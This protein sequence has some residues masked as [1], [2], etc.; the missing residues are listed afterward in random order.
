MPVP[1]GYGYY[2][3]LS[4]ANGTTLSAFVCRVDLS[5]SNF[6]FA[7]CRADGA[8][9]RPYDETADVVLPYWLRDFDRDAQKGSLRFLATATN[10]VIKI[11]YGNSG[12]SSASMYLQASGGVFLGGTGFDVPDWGDLATT[13]AGAT[14]EVAALPKSA[15]ISD[16]R[17]R[18]A[19]R[20]RL[21]PAI[22]ANAPGDSG[23]R[24]LSIVTDQYGRIVTDGSGNW[25]CYIG[26]QPAAGP[27][28]T[29]RATSSDE[30]ET[31][32]GW[33]LA[34]S[35]G[36]EAYDQSGAMAGTVIRVSPTSFYMFYTATGIAGG[37]GLATAASIMGPWTKQGIVIPA[38]TSLITSFACISV[39]IPHVRRMSDGTWTMVC[40]VRANTPGNQVWSI[41]G[42]QAS[43]IDGPWTGMNGGAVL[44]TGGATPWGSVGFADPILEEITPSLYSLFADG[45]TGSD[46]TNW[47]SF[48][49]QAGWFTNST[50]NNSSWAPDPGS[51]PLGMKIGR[52]GEHTEF[53]GV[54]PTTNDRV[55]FAARFETFDATNPYGTAFKIHPITRR[56][57][58]LV[59]RAVGDAAIAGKSLAA[60]N[61]VCESS[62]YMTA[63]RSENTDAY[64]LSLIDVASLPTPAPSSTFTGIFRV[65]IRRASFDHVSNPGGIQL[66]YYT[67]LDV[68]TFWDGS[69]WGT[70][71]AW[72]ASDTARE[73]IARIADDGS[74][75]ILTAAYADDDSV[76]ATATVSKATVKPFVNPRFML[77]GDMFT[78]AAADGM[79]Y[80]QVGVRP[81]PAGGVEPAYSLGAEVPIGVGPLPPVVSER[82][83]E[84]GTPRLLEDGSSRLL[85][86]SGMPTPGES[87]RLLE[88]GTTR[89]LEDG[90]ARLLEES[91]GVPLPIEAG[92]GLATYVQ[93]A[94]AIDYTPV[95]DIGGGDVIV[96]GG[97]V[98]VTKR[99]IFAGELGALRVEGGF[100]VDKIDGEAISFMDKIYW[101]DTAKV[102]TA[103]VK[104]VVMGRCIRAALADDFKV[105]VKLTFGR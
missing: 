38:N 21:T 47:G 6:G 34:L 11:C 79:F 76:I 8:D 102:A 103:V 93:K 94:D 4:D 31:W 53:Q 81:Y 84:D 32:T 105:R 19:W 57:G 13:S 7:R 54:H 69:A 18:R 89:L 24:N 52:Y 28:R 61:V 17:Q 25:V 88:D 26:S 15:G 58:L 90:T 30:G 14:S 82:L 41:G 44:L 5:A 12:A 98:G 85:E 100:S 62:S 104:P 95:I 74:S 68:P 77:V 60:G 87:E 97:Y 29:M 91:G 27:R 56:G 71:P 16:P 73:V 43:S 42:F 59:T 50:Y 78:N 80:T 10:H 1:S 65:T 33:T 35:P 2:R 23:V 92:P 55:S 51:P 63:H 48:D 70:T 46:S 40:E 37:V 3:P 101:D 86:E 20:R 39:A 72:V 64:L 75:F 96:I 36:P 49:F 45:Q 99:R 9:I 67:A 22:A 66:V 83:L